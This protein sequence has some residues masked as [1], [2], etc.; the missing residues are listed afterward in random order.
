M[1]E[2][3]ASQHL[4]EN[5][6]KTPFCL[7]DLAA[8]QDDVLREKVQEHVKGIALL[9]TLKHAFNKNLQIYFEQILINIFQK[10]DQSGNRDEVIDLLYYLLNE[11]QFLDKNRFL[12]LLHQEFHPDIEGRVMTIAQQLRTEG[13]LEGWHEGKLEGKLEGTLEGKLEGE[14]EGRIDIAKRLLA[15]GTD[16]KTVAELTNLP[17]AKI[18]MLQKHILDTI[19]TS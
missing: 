5:F 19:V 10:L 11:G 7:I 16:A 4:F 1:I 8:I 3:E 18:E 9:M 17:L 6:F 2:P 14:L 12:R 15:R 13:K